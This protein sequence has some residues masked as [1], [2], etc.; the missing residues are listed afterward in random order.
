MFNS[1]FEILYF[2]DYM[3]KKHIDEMKASLRSIHLNEDGKVNGQNSHS[4]EAAN[5]GAY[6]L[7]GKNLSLLT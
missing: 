7:K 3:G 5:R 1:E 6:V 4:G 2:G